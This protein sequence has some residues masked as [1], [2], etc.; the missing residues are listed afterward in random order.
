MAVTRD[1]GSERYFKGMKTPSGENGRSPNR[2]SR[3]IN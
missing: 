2:I 1:N 3:E